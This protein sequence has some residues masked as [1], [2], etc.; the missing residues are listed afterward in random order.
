MW[1]INVSTLAIGVSLTMIH[2]TFYDL[3]WQESIVEAFLRKISISV[4]RAGLCLWGRI[5]E[6]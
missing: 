3:L 5:V 1:H 2:V 6:R 4:D